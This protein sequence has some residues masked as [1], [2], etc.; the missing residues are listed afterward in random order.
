RRRAMSRNSESIVSRSRTSVS[1]RVSRR[2][3]KSSDTQHPNLLGPQRTHL[4][5]IGQIP[6]GQRRIQPS[7]LGPYKR[8]WTPANGSN[9]PTDQKVGTSNLFG[10]TGGFGATTGGAGGA[11][12]SGGL[13][14]GLLGPGG[15]NGGAGGFSDAGVGGAG[16]AGGSAG[17]LGF[18]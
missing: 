6:A 7:E 16:G 13:L 12:G 10:G 15:G 3:H 1:L 9:P 4:D 11:G 18:A 17:L 2:C 8:Q 5:Q 14:S